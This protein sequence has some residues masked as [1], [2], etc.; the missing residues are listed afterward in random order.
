MRQQPL[1]IGA[2]PAGCAAAIRLGRAGHRPLMI[3][4]GTGPADKVCGDFLSADTIAQASELGI[5]PLAL[6]AAPIERM[7][8]VHHGRVVETR[9]PFNAVGLSRRVFDA[10]LTER[11]VQAGAVVRNGQAV[12]QIVRGRDTWSVQLERGGSLDATTVFL[13]TGK[14][15]V[16]DMPRP[17][18]SDGA[19]GLKMYYRPSADVAR[20][21][22]NTTE[23]ILFPGGYAG[24]QPVEDGRIVVC[25]AVRPG[26]LKAIG[27]WDGLLAGNAYLAE[28]L[29]AAQPLLSRTLAI[30][31]VPYGYLAQAGAAGLFRLGDQGAVIPSLTGDG[32]SIALHSGSS[33]ANAWVAG[34]DAAIWQRSLARTLAPQMK[35]AGFLHDVALSAAGQSFGIQVAGLWP[36]LLRVFAS[37]TRLRAAP[38]CSNPTAYPGPHPAAA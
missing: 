25:V 21:L 28:R 18:R 27:G 23:L 35:L 3:E 6:G 24:V 19:V 7:R 17:G 37:R 33:A 26:T 5:D 12:R 1:I 2:G 32:M 38:V 34:I 14:H 16:R 20:D 11:A 4:R 30:A 8:L 15:D 36:G 13:A 9:L 29:R 31:G 10:A 22:A